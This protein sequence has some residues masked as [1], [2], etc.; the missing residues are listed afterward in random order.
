MQ[1]EDLKNLNSTEG[2][3]YFD[4]DLKKLN[5]FNIG[6]KAKIFFKAETLRGL[7]EFLKIYKKR[8]KIF[9]LG[10][11]SNVLITDGIFD[12][13][14]IKL[15]KNFQNL[16][17]LN[18]NMIIAGCGITQK[19]LSEFSRENNMAGMEFLSCIP[20][21]V[22]GGIR[23]NSGC[24][25]REFKDILTSVQC[26]DFEGKVKM[27][28]KKKVNFEYRG[29]DLSKDLIFLSGTFIGKKGERNKIQDK[30]IE[31][32]EKKEN[33]QPTKVKT[34]GSTFKN[35]KDQT[36]KKVWELIK[37]AVPNS[38]TFG[39]A[40]ISDKHSNFFIN[41]KDAS[42]H[43]MKKLIITVKD[44]VQKKTGVKINPE[45]VIIE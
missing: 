39:D 8:G 13:A 27:I 35:P 45:I 29:S 33:A 42:F 1:L 37:E 26:I 4:H 20:G 19:K 28:D 36:S 41:K 5:W 23:M 15:G 14:V 18:E 11:G 38:L 7:V 16:S 21:S 12:G 6:G 34:G 44:A 31:L 9:V 10:A 43:D 24:F 3:I 22:G 32:K 30:M 25:D 17:I 40:T 2:K